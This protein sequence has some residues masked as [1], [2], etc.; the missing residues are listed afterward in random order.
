[1]LP[2][3]DAAGLVS[4]ISPLMTRL[5]ELQHRVHTNHF[6]GLPMLALVLAAFGRLGLRMACYQVIPRCRAPIPSSRVQYSLRGM[7]IGLF[8]FKRQ[9]F[10]EISLDIPARASQ[11]QGASTSG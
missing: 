5:R 3:P 8:L 9:L 11:K 10:H 1:M 2:S 4:R 7:Q 6:H